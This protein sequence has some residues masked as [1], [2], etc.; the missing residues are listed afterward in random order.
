MLEIE[1]DSTINNLENDLNRKL[2]SLFPKEEAINVGTKNSIK[3]ISLEE[4]LRELLEIN[5]SIS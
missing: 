2:N 5:K 3:H 4:A 1:R